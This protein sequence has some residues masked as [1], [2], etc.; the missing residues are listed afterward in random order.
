MDIIMISIKTICR[1]D[2]FKVITLSIY[3][4]KAI[5]FLLLYTKTLS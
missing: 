2:I 4:L 3:V 5:T 1:Q